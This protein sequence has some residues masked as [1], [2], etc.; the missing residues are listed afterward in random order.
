M[1]TFNEYY[2]TESKND[3]PVDIFKGYK[4]ELSKKSSSKRT[5]IVVRSS[6]RDSDRDSIGHRLQSNGIPFSVVPSSFSSFDPI[7]LVYDE[8]KYLLLFKADT[9]GMQETT[10]NSTITELFP[11]MAFEKNF[12]S[13]DPDEL[14]KFVISTDIETLDCVMGPDKKQAI[15]FIAAAETSSKFKEKLENAIAILKFLRDKNNDK[16]IDIAYWGYRTKPSGV[17]SN[18][19]GDM[20]LKFNDGNILGVSLKA[21]GKKTKEPLLNTYVNKIFDLFGEKKLYDNLKKA[22]YNQVFSQLEGIPSFKTYDG[23]SNGRHKDR[24]KT[25][26]ILRQLDKA[27]SKTYEGGYNRYLQIMRSGIIG[28][29]NEDKDES[30]KYIKSE[31][32][33]DAPDVP[34]IVIKGIGSNY[35]EVKDVDELGVFIPQVKFIK[36]YE[37]STSKQNWFIQLESGDDEL[38][39]NMSIRSNKSG[40][41]GVKKLGQ[42]SLAVKFNGIGKRR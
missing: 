23:G 18:H 22:V 6:D 12:Y 7:E 11:C 36:A 41:A 16:S 2:F 25:E 39:M 26:E 24:R 30:L 9:G 29:F 31:I 37:S 14:Y 28:L 15:D 21:G 4:T 10:L 8:F 3:L 20:F 27:D 42:F 34:T 33:R 5:V 35:E 38:I 19:P 40:N 1:K 32:L 17:P 13:E